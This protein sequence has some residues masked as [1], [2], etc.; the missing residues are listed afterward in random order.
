MHLPVNG[1]ED[2]AFVVWNRDLVLGV[3]AASGIRLTGD[4]VVSIGSSVLCRFSAFSL[5]C[6]RK[7]L[8]LLI[9]WAPE[10]TR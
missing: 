3:K 6:L 2:A 10:E 7:A 9:N 1:T 8:T 5:H 4:T